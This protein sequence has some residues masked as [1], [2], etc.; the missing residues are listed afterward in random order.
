[1]IKT[2]SATNCSE[3]CIEMYFCPFKKIHLNKSPGCYRP[4]VEDSS[5]QINETLGISPTSLISTGHINTMEFCRWQLSFAIICSGWHQR[6]I[7]ATNYLVNQETMDS[8]HR[9][10]T[11][12]KSVPCDDVINQPLDRDAYFSVVK[13]FCHQGYFYVLTHLQHISRVT[14][15]V[16]YLFWF[17]VD[18]YWLIIILTAFF[19]RRPHLVSPHYSF[20]LG[21]ADFP[22]CRIRVDHIQLWAAAVCKLPSETKLVTIS[23]NIRPGLLKAWW[24]VSS[25]K[26]EIAVVEADAGLINIYYMRPMLMSSVHVTVYQYASQLTMIRSQYGAYVWIS[27]AIWL[28]QPY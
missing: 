10:S 8:P 12:R 20:F 26:H 1:M 2:L 15:A 28:R 22:N 27:C 25:K 9:G 16:R 6:W 17:I 11:I 19:G 14:Y 7:K 13:L 24:I 21:C 4:F 18:K 3:T 5:C 23:I